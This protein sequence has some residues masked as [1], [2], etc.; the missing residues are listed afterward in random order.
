MHFD[1]LGANVTI[2]VVQN[3][4]DICLEVGGLK[5][6]IFLIS[7]SSLYSKLAGNH[8]KLVVRYKIIIQ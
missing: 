5:M 4:I 2:L 1:G 8:T 7:L 3:I 6:K